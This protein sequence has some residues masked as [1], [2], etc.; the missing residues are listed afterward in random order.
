M[1]TTLIGAK[2]PTF[3]LADHTG[4]VW[5]NADLAGQFTIIYAYPKAMTS[6]CTAESCDFRDNLKAFEKLSARVL[7]LS[8]DDVA[9]QA[10]FVEKEKLTFPLLADPEKSLLTKLGIWIEKSLY[11]RKYMGIDR[12]T[13]LID[14]AGLVV[15]EWRRVKV[16][17]HVAEVA[18]RLRA[19]RP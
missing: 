9:R 2:F 17:G 15:A 12:S 5:T 19:E 1:S 8:A 16:P 11:G 18:A 6:G 13:F 10:K 14:P 7:G 3:K 4:R